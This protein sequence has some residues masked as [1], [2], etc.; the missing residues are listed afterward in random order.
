[1]GTS[2]NLWNCQ[3]SEVVVPVFTAGPVRWVNRKSS[4]K[5]CF[6]QSRTTHPDASGFLQISLR[7]LSII[8][9]NTKHCIP[10]KK[11]SGAE[12]ILLKQF[13]ESSVLLVYPGTSKEN[14]GYA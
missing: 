4:L 5:G 2:P 7:H 3:R 14:L 1:M 8:V 12:M 13:E 11:S 10:E 9:S 6:E